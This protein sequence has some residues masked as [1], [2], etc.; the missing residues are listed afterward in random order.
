MPEAHELPISSSTS[1]LCA[2]RTAAEGSVDFRSR[3][4]AGRSATEEDDDDDDVEAAVTVERWRRTT[5]IT[6]SAARTRLSSTGEPFRKVS[7][8]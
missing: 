3:G 7:S 4:G 2:R 5:A 8:S 1:D 6:T